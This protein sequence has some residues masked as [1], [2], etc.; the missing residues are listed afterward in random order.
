MKKLFYFTF[1]FA[2]SVHAQENDSIMIRKFFNEE[3]AKGKAYGLLDH[4]SNKIGGRLSGSPQAAKAVDWGK[5]TMEFLGFDKVWVQE[6]M[7]PHWVRGEKEQAKIIS[8]NEKTDVRICALG[9]SIGTG[10]KG[11][12]ANV[13]EVKSFKELENL[14]RKNIEGKIVFFNRA[15]DPTF[16]STGSAYGN[17]VDQRGG[18]AVEAAKYGAIGVV[19]R[20]MTLSLDDHPHTGAM[21]YKDSITKIPACAI[22]TND[23]NRLSDA[24]KFNKETKFYF[25]QT[26]EMLADEQSFNVIGELHGSQFPDEIIVV[27]GH[28]DSW[29]TGDGASDDGTG[30]VQSIEALRLFKVLGIRPRR[31]IRAVLYMNEENGARGGEKYAELAKKN[32]EKHIA[33]IESDG[34]GFTPRSFGVD[35]ENAVQKMQPWVELLKQYGIMEIKKGW[36]GVDIGPLKKQGTVMIGYTCDGQRYFDYHH[37]EIDTFDKVNKR[38][39]E[40]GTGCIAA[41]LWLISEYGL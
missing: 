11:I 25:K 40:L 18:G 3:L 38:E 1:L 32:N 2:F 19:V 41:L 7:V 23:A 17:A 29:D 13:I 14:G 36:G 37:S 22:S 4:L 10:S 26:C 31:T 9:N 15:L 20:S 34:G 24:I 39:L 21:W 12:T 30:I 27:G 16:I 33:A 5:R 6:V 35:D 28:L 8:G